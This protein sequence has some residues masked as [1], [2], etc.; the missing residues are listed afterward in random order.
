MVTK[1]CA[2]CKGQFPVK[3]YRLD[4]AKYCSYECYWS[5]SS[6]KESIVCRACGVEQASGQFQKVGRGFESRC[7]SC[8][9]REWR[10]WAR[11][12]TPKQRFY[13][14]ASRAKNSGKEFTVS[15]SQ[16]ADL[17]GCGACFYCGRDERLGLDR[18]DS[19]RGYTPDN[20]V[21]CC[22]P[23]NVAKSDLPQRD[24]I[25]LCRMIS[26]RHASA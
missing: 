6:K 22:R 19:S 4:E 26:E 20:V 17:V 5:K 11:S 24:F 3:P 12:N 14:Y 15:E 9:R 25:N 8:K 2:S 21:P 18:V 23:C 13:F 1:E 7:R 10:N 16:F